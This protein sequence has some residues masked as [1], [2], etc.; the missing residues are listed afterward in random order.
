MDRI[1]EVLWPDDPPADPAANVAT[2][3]SRT[4]RLL[5]AGRW[6]WAGPAPTARSA[7]RGR[8]TWTRPARVCA[9]A[10]DR[11]GG[12]RARRSPRPRPPRPWTCSVRAALLDEA[13]ADWVARGAARGRRAAPARGRR[14]P[15]RGAT[16]VDPAAAVR[17]AAEGVARRPVRRA[18]V[19]DLM[20]ALSPTAV[21]RRR[22]RRTTAWR[23]RLRDEL[24]TDPDRATAELHLALLRETGRSRP[25]TGPRTRAEPPRAVVGREDRARARGAGLGRRGRDGTPTCCWSRVRP[26]SARPGCWTRWP[27]WPAAGRAGAARR[28]ATRPSARCSSSPTSTRSRPV[29]LELPPRPGAAGARPRGALG[30]RWCPSSAAG[31]AAGAG[32]P[33]D[34]DLQRRARTTRWR[35]CCAGWPSGRRCCWP[36][37]TCRTAA[38]RRSTCSATWPGGWRTARVLLVGGG[39]HRGRRDSSRGWP[40]GP[41]SCAL[42]ALPRSAVDALAAAAGLGDARR[43]GDGA[44]RRSHAQRRRVPAGAGRRRRRGPRVAGRGGAARVRTGSTPRCAPCSG[45]ARCWAAGSTRACWPT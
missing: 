25:R 14:P 8:S 13:D 17:V 43:G 40:T 44:H 7:A 39:P 45:P 26:G 9:E 24:G 37:T 15:G 23:G 10:A 35:P 41:R 11:L 5:G 42:A 18:A 28:G 36:S 21:P 1:V 32:A 38:P 19:R 27:S 33:A 34:R 2:L 22:W 30:R 29:L 20:R 31:A 16:V 4:R 12:G 3:V 6:S